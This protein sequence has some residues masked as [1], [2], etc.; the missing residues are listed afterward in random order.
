MLKYL[1]SFFRSGSTAAA[2]PQLGLQ[3]IFSQ[4]VAPLRQDPLVERLHSYH[5]TLRKASFKTTTYSD[6]SGKPE[7]E[8]LIGRVKWSYT[9]VMSNAAATSS[10]KSDE[11]QGEA[12]LNDDLSNA[13]N[14]VSD[15]HY[16]RVAVTVHNHY[17]LPSRIMEVC[18]DK[19]ALLSPTDKAEL[20]SA[21]SV[22]FLTYKGDVESVPLLHQYAALSLVAACM[23]QDGGALG[24][25]NVKA[26]TAASAHLLRG[27]SS[28]SSSSSSFSL[29]GAGLPAA[30]SIGPDG[31]MG[32]TQQPLLTSLM[33]GMGLATDLHNP[34]EG[35]LA[36]RTFGADLLSLP[37]FVVYVPSLECVPAAYC[38]CAMLWHDA[39]RHGTPLEGGQVVEMPRYVEQ[40]L[41]INRPTLNEMNATKDRRILVL[42]AVGG[43]KRV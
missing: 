40:E 42:H 29:D 19:S 18:V 25:V 37:N 36:L 14:E 20:H 2:L 21:R 30:L 3:V 11:A 28:S 7:E 9:P 10:S 17:Q 41:H 35:L 27:T 39:L 13:S 38:S 34:T 23:A 6:D 31:V 33:C 26:H 15:T 8:G 24:V 43:W 32:Y 22:A 1:T 12:A 16:H 4:T 5:P